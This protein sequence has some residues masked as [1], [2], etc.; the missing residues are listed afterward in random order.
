MLDPATAAERIRRGV[1]HNEGI[2]VFPFSS[3][4]MWFACRL[5]PT[6]LDG[7]LSKVIERFRASRI[8]Q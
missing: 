8:R 4:L 5:R 1:E 3:K 6:A 7:L 2:I